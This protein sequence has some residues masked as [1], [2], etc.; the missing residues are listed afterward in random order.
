VQEFI[1]LHIKAHK[2]M[3]QD[4]A[5]QAMAQQQ[6]MQA[7]PMPGPEQMPLDGMAPA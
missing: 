4:M 2:K 7:P 1:D 3:Q 6:A 5:M